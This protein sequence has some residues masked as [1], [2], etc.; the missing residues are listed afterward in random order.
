MTG[1]MRAHEDAKRSKVM[2]KQLDTGS[3]NRGTDVQGIAGDRY[4]TYADR[5]TLQ[6]EEVSERG[7]WTDERRQMRTARYGEAKGGV[8]E[9]GGEATS[10]GERR[11]RAEG[12]EARSISRE[13]KNTYVS[14]VNSPRA[15]RSSELAHACPLGRQ[16]ARGLEWED[17]GLVE[18]SARR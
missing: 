16:E 6:R 13:K 9:K 4:E 7:G 10:V 14:V 5:R 11:A 15:S 12:G 8:S 2:H 1:M 3:K 17:H 18:G